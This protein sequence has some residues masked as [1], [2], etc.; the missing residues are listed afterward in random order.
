MTTTLQTVTLPNGITIADAS[1]DDFLLNSSKSAAEAIANDRPAVVL[2]AIHVG[3]LNHRNEQTYLDALAHSDAVYA[4]GMAVVTLA[5]LAGAKH[6]ERTPTTDL[7]IPLV[8]RISEELGRPVRVALVGGPPGLAD[9]AAR[10]LSDA[11]P[12]SMALTYDGFADIEAPDVVVDALTRES[13]DL[14]IVGLGVPRETIWATWL[15]SRLQATAI[16]TCG[17]WFG[18]LA[19]EETRAPRWMQRLGLEWAGRLAQSPRR[20]AKRYAV[21]LVTT[22]TLAG[23]VVQMRIAERSAGNR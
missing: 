16:I 17:G 1:F 6:V 11:C 21:G 20:L 19:G 9:R 5:R 18:F 8:S 22:A 10:A 13:I 2:T 23:Q 7:G 14:V 3:G 12:V 15:A 4:D